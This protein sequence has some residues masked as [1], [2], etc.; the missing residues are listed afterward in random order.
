MKI[1]KARECENQSDVPTYRNFQH[2]VFTLETIKQ[3]ET[4]EISEIFDRI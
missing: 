3:A 1:H 2:N 4:L